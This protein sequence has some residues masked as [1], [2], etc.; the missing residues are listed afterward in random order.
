MSVNK[1]PNFI[2]LMSHIERSDDGCWN[3]TGAISKGG[4]GTVW[5]QTP[6]GRKKV[7]AHR[8][9]YES[10][11]G[12][13]FEGRQIDHLCRNRR[14]ANPAHLESVTQREN[15]M[16][17][18]APTILLYHANECARGHSLLEAY[19]DKRGRRYCRPCARLTRDLE[20]NREYLRKRRAL[21]KLEAA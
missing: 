6:D 11:V 12:N 19:V 21:K 20:K 5:I 13:I 8:L 10:L 7:Y 9:S 17:G 15:L 14:C 18:Q 16:R 4:Y 3:W 1:T 2:R